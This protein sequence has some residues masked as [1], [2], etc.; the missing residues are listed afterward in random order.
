MPSSRCT[1]GSIG[2]SAYPLASIAKP[3]GA[4]AAGL[5]SMANRIESTAL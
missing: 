5:C 3:S 1:E 2:I 4:D